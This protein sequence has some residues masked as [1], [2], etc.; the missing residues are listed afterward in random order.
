MGG[1]PID[2][3]QMAAWKWSI[4]TQMESQRELIENVKMVPFFSNHYAALS[5][6]SGLHEIP[7]MIRT[8]DVK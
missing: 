8:R 5:K 2:S 6:G 4:H 7:T 3:S 1:R